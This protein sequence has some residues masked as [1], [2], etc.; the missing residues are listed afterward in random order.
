M[1]N[2]VRLPCGLRTGSGPR[3]NSRRQPVTCKDMFCDEEP[4]QVQEF[5]TFEGVVE[6]FGAHCEKCATKYIHPHADVEAAH[7]RAMKH[8]A[9]PPHMLSDKWWS[10]RLLNDTERAAIEAIK[11]GELV[12][13]YMD[14]PGVFEWCPPRVKPAWL[15]RCTTVPQDNH[16]PIDCLEVEFKKQ[17]VP[18]RRT[19]ARDGQSVLIV[20][21]RPKYYFAND[22]RYLT[23][24]RDLETSEWV[25]SDALCYTSF[26]RC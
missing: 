1:Q 17:G 3:F 16:D 23:M 2:S 22:R 26:P 13:T 15:C 19:T 8:S 21:S 25:E 18:H 5:T 11:R 12:E 24:V 20:A 7:D 9:Q 6:C 4:T 14:R 10:A